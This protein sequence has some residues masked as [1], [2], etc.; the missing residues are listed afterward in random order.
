MAKFQSVIWNCKKVHMRDWK[1]APCMVTDSP[2]KKFVM[3]M[4]L[5]Q[6]IV[7]INPFPLKKNRK[8]QILADFFDFFKKPSALKTG[9]CRNL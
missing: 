1:Y 7:R 5:R 6:C 3:N 9:I 8:S 4:Q 2:K